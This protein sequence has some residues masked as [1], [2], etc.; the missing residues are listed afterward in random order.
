MENCN[1]KRGFF[2]LRDCDHPA[3]QHCS[4]CGKAFCNDHLRIKPGTNEPVCLDCLGKI[5][6]QENQEKTA[7]TRSRNHYDDY[8][9]DTAWCYGY[10]RNYY[11]AHYSPWYMGDRHDAQFDEHDVRSFEPAG[12][13]DDFEA[14]APDPEA[15]VFDS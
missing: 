3:H 1:M 12:E 11:G 6:Q 8:Y 10:R 5:M 9:Y 4:V 13:N 2:F 15:N 7:R 14:E